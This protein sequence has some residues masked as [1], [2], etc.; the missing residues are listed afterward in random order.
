MVE[1]AEVREEATA[2]HQ[3]IKQTGGGE[4][5]L[6][7]KVKRGLWREGAGGGARGTGVRT[8]AKDRALARYIQQSEQ[9]R[10]VTGD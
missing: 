7:Q 6:W 4:T 10:G 1:E 8:G 9:Q 3:C 5:A 2:E